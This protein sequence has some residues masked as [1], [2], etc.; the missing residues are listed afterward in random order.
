M[1]HKRRKERD[2]KHLLMKVIEEVVRLYEIVMYVYECHLLLQGS[3][4]SHTNI[5]Q[6][7]I[8]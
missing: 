6:Q 8:P 5:L 3:E 2:L 1:N 4:Q 7:F